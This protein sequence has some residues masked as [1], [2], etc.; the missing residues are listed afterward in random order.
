MEAAFRALH[1][2]NVARGLDSVSGTGSTMPATRLL[3]ERLARVLARLQIR[4]LL[5]AGCGDRGWIGE[6]AADLDDYLGVDVLEELQSVG[7]QPSLRFRV[8]N[9]IE[10]ALPQMDAVLCR[11]CLTQLPL[12]AARRALGNLASTGAR[13]VI[14]T[15]FPSVQDNRPSGFG[16]WRPL[17]LCLPPFDLPPPIQLVAERAPHP[18]DKYQDKALGIWESHALELLMAEVPTKPDAH[19]FVHIPK[20]TGT[21]FRIAVERRFGGEAV[22]YD[23][24]GGPETHPLVRA[25]V[26][27]ERD[28]IALSLALHETKVRL[29]GGHVHFSKYRTIFPPE[30]LMTFLCEPI[31]RV[32]SEY[33]HFCRHNGFVGSLLEFAERPR[34]QNLQTSMLAGAPLVDLAFLGISERYDDSLVVLQRRLGWRIEPLVLNVNPEQKQ[35]AG[36][37]ELSSEERR[38]LERWNE[39]DLELYAKARE[40][41]QQSLN[42]R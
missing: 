21:S 5:D 35:L 6:I 15:T 28:L 11:D 2:A 33:K 37:Y 17:N 29:L 4:R 25:H 10:D 27:D 18:D 16:G 42:Q 24:G 26:H 36:S 39:S 23:Y 13:Y 14:A 34:N 32:A 19:L 3:R 20:T 1:E 12:E 40:L 7:D 30:R 9:I 38:Q 8:A 31:A 22:A 41:F